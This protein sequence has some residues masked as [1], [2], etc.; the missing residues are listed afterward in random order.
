M[1]DKTPMQDMVVILPGI[2]GSVLQKDG[3]DLWAVSGQAI[4]D[5]VKTQV[6]YQS[7]QKL[8]P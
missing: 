8:L 7:P 5:I 6:E 1:A 3:K 2:T 4:W